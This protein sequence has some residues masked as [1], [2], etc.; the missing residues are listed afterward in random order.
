MP[1]SRP[2]FFVPAERADQHGI[3]RVGGELSSPWLVDAYRHGIFPWPSNDGWLAWW[4]PDPR[5]IFELDGLHISRRLERTLRSGKFTVTLDQAF[6]Q[7]I[8]GC[9]SAQERADETWI[10]PEMREAYVQLHREGVA[11]SVETWHEGQLAGGIYG[12]AIGGLF[13]GESMFYQVRDG[14]KVALVKL[15]EHL[16]ERGYRL[17]D[18]Q[19]VTPHT[20]SLGAKYIGRREYLRRLAEAVELPVTWR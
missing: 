13:A 15:V 17:F 5:G 9:A 11:H 20:E 1:L 7:V 19:M 2:R 18:V 14:S 8:D 6:E 3:V 10:L 12:V 16:V 4:S